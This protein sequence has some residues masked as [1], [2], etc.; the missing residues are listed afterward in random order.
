[1]GPNTMVEFYVVDEE[2]IE[3]LHRGAGHSHVSSKHQL[4]HVWV[5]RASEVGA[6]DAQIFSV[7]T[8]LGKTL[9]IGDTVMG[10]FFYSLKSIHRL[11]QS[12]FFR[13]RSC[14]H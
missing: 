4:S 14:E 3:D 13:L 5:S 7:R 6:P 2:E 1:M 9:R 10:E 12:K 11:I 8:H